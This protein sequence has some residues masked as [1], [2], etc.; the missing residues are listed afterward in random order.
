MWSQ[1]AG[2]LSLLSVLPH[3]PYDLIKV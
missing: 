1:V 2:Q 3:Q